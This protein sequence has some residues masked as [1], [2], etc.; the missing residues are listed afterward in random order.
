[1]ADSKLII[2]IDGDT[3]ELKKSLSEIE[4]T[5][6]KSF[7]GV[8]DSAKKSEENLK[9]N[10]TETDKLGKGFKDTGKKGKESF[11]DIDESIKDTKTSTEKLRSSL[12][13]L[14]GVAT[15]GL[16]ALTAVGTAI[17]G[18]FAYSA[19]E[20]MNYQT[21]LSKVM[22]IA[23]TSKL[24]LESLR[25]EVLELSDKTGIAAADLNEAVYSAISASVDSADAVSFVEQAVKLAKGGFTDTAT[26]VDVMTTALNAY[27][28]EADQTS[29]IS[30]ILIATQNRGKTTVGEL[31]S[32]IGK[33]IPTAAAFRVDMENLGAS[34]AILT[35][36]GI[37]T[38]EATTYLNGMLNELGKDGAQAS[39]NLK[40][41]TGKSF[42]QLS[43]E[44]KNLGEVIAL[45]QDYAA[46]SGKKIS[47]M[48]GSIEAGKAA[49]TIA[50]KGVSEY[51]DN[52]ASMTG[53]AGA[54][55]KAFETMES[56]SGTSIEKL[57]TRFQN[58][59]ID[60]GTSLLPTISNVSN[61]IG[62]S[63]DS[64]AVKNSIE[65]LKSSASGLVSEFGKFAL[66][67]IPKVISGLSWLAKNFS[68]V[69]KT[70][71]VFFA[72]LKTLKAAI[73]VINTVKNAI[74]LISPAIKVD[75]TAAK[76]LWA[77]MAANPLG[78]V[79]IGI[80]ALVSIIGIFAASSSGATK[81]QLEL[82]KSIQQNG[83]EIENLTSKV[84][85]ISDEYNSSIDSIQD[86]TVSKLAEIEA[87]KNLVSELEN[88]LDANGKVK[89]GY[90]E[91]VDYILNE[92]N[93]AYGTELSRSDD[94]ITKN[95]E[96]IN[97]YGEIKN[98]IEENM[99]TSMAAAIMKQY[100]DEYAAAVK[101]VADM[102]KEA[103]DATKKQT[104]ALETRQTL[105]DDVIKKL[106]QWS[107]EAANAEDA[108]E[109]LESGS[110]QGYSLDGTSITVALTE[111]TE[112][113]QKN[114]EQIKEC[115]NIIEDYSDA[116]NELAIIESKVND[117]RAANAENNNKKIIN[118]YALSA[119]EIKHIN[120]Q[121]TSDLL[122]DLNSRK[123]SIE[124]TMGMIAA[125]VEKGDKETANN[126][127]TLLKTQISNLKTLETEY[128]N[129]GG[130]APTE[131]VKELEL[132]QGVIEIAVNESGE[133]AINAYNEV[134]GREKWKICATNSIAG[135]IDVF[136][137]AKTT[138]YQAG[139]DIGLSF[140]TGYKTADKQ[141]S[142]SK[143]MRESGRFTIK[144][145]ENGLT[146]GINMAKGLGFKTGEA[147]K[148]G[149]K[150]SLDINSP[151]KEMS[152]LA[153]DT[154]DGLIN[155]LDER[156]KDL[157]KLA[158]DTGD[159][160]LKTAKLYALEKKRLED[161]NFDKEYAEKLKNAKDAK[162]AEKIKQDYISKA[163]KEG[164][165]AYLKALKEAADYE[166]EEY[167]KRVKAAEDFQKNIQKT[168]ENLKK[169]FSDD[170]S[171]Y[172][173]VTVKMDDGSEMSWYELKDLSQD[174]EVIRAYAEK[175][176]KLQKLLPEDMYNEI[177]DMKMSDGSILVDL[178]LSLSSQDLE[179]QIEAW[180][181]YNSAVDNSAFEIT[182][183][184]Y[185]DDYLANTEKAEKI[186]D[187]TSKSFI[188]GFISNLSTLPELVATALGRQNI[189]NNTQNT[190]NNQTNNYNF[191]GSK[192][193]VFQQRQEAKRLEQLRIARGLI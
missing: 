101:R 140:R 157:I 163:Q 27:G 76:G 137:P 98:A 100:E 125:A 126:L 53:A 26:A 34:M 49:L 155:Q 12:N 80:T 48:F 89:E 22:T 141:K 129:A 73:S 185:S 47:D 16:A 107:I 112:A 145:L 144:G 135:L 133:A 1:M 8:S 166:K 33:V 164:Q 105:I 41:A 122:D 58:M 150:E 139:Y 118:S 148:G 83:Q 114:N 14:D 50:N 25:N 11:E 10:K 170:Y 102:T 29:R 158:E 42:E 130:N 28:L 59:A 30:D 67:I 5:S 179:K 149:Y 72:A 45:L 81:K 134:A 152:K 180:Q 172:R 92:M 85:E 119:D 184:S 66:Q 15:K 4:K 36:N 6:K 167:D 43:K 120:Q 191:N 181:K 77:V 190:V 154:A 20:A 109:A 70:T 128:K 178:L 96:V 115:Q 95:G 37:A 56:T 46:K 153:D 93:N 165:D 174:A 177:R 104:K 52:L 188:S 86:S 123:S 68:T 18:A 44:G 13:D 69:A 40:K 162:E 159:D 142:P 17:G 75:T 156:T 94:V 124:N 151:S 7:Q 110:F 71:L 147:Y 54:T 91:R 117:S 79:I 78:A 97:S 99:E 90:E 3:K 143:A 160:E 183:N 39:E 146:P 131:F 31:G 19:K 63:F 61:A 9:K 176:L 182:K 60:I 55:E 138:M 121:N 2:K 51:N 103:D 161:E 108:I 74:S 35:A 57:R 132:K 84:K 23:D 136:G 62:E 32:S 169:I 21:S 192:M 127:Y 24:P 168:F 65:N 187:E 106:Q 175:L 193:T 116:Q 87:D 113:W 82:Q 111:E 173:K 88:L 171:M 189:T 38:A 64:P 186:A